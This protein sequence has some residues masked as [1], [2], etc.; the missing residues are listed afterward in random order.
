MKYTKPYNLQFDWN[1]WK[2]T[3]EKG[4]FCPSYTLISL[5][6]HAYFDI[7]SVLFE[8]EIQAPTSTLQRALKTTPSEM[9]TW[10]LIVVKFNLHMDTMGLLQASCT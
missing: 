7:D 9:V 1:A 3:M 5:S 10:A 6:R 2:H 8:N 4:W